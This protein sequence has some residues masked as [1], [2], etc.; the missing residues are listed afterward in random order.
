MLKKG[1]EE[2]QAQNSKKENKLN[3]VADDCCLLRSCVSVVARSIW[4]QVGVRT[5]WLMAFEC[6][7]NW[8]H[9]W[10]VCLKGEAD[11][12]FGCWEVRS[13]EDCRMQH[14]LTLKSK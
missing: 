4:L 6:P 13:I 9:L 8:T 10:S 5:S 2:K 12:V 1:E 7:R 14:L 11:R 3:L